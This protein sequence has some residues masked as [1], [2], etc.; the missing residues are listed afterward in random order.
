MKKQVFLPVCLLLLL[1]GSAGA[2]NL[3]P[4]ASFTDDVNRDF[5]FAGCH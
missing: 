3:P 1:V 5:F 4:L 2:N